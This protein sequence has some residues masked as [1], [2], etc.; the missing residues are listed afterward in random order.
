MA[1]SFGD[2]VLDLRDLARLVSP[3]PTAMIAPVHVH[4]HIPPVVDKPVPQEHRCPEQA[5][6]EAVRDEIKRMMATNS[7]L[8]W[9]L[10]ALQHADAGSFNEDVIAEWRHD[11][12]L[13]ERQLQQSLIRERQGA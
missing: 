13:Q 12:Q 5:L 6:S 3:M 7:K 1:R 9:A 11:A 4:F 10:D 2:L 8:L